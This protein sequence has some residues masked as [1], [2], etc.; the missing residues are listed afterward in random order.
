MLE[1]AIA[2]D[3]SYG[4]ALAWTAVCHLQL[5]T[6]GWA[7]APAETRRKAVDLARRALQIGGADPGILAHSAFVLARCGED[8]GA[9]IG[10]V[11]RALALNP[12]FAAGWFRSG[13]LRLFAGQPDLAI[14][15]VERSLRLSPHERIGVPLFAIGTGHLF[16]RRFNE[17]ASKLALSIQDHPGFPASYRALAA[18]YAHMGRLDEARAIVAELRTITPLV[19]P[20]ELPF[21]DPEQRELYLS[22]LELAMGG[23]S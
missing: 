20:S 14:Q 18:C 2:I 13:L 10:L 6:D 5:V 19:V 15:H 22:G 4:L 7:E 23:T 9:M 11:E 21:R 17:A 16:M 12:S 8:I 1:R 3:P